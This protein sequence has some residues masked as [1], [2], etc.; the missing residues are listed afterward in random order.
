MGQG[1]PPDMRR[2]ISAIPS[3]RR[4]PSWKPPYRERG[5]R[6]WERT[7]SHFPFLHRRYSR[8]KTVLSPRSNIKGS[9]ISAMGKAHRP[10][11]RSEEHTSEL[12]SPDHLVCRLLLEKKKNNHQEQ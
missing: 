8:T 5:L 2:T 4:P 1:S 9:L 3:K 11:A 7:R 10:G 12:Q 6:K